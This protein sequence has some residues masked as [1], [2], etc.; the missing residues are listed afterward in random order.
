MKK[1]LLLFFAAILLV[2]TSC[3]K[4]N[5]NDG[6]SLTG[7]EGVWELRNSKSMLIS[8]YPPGNGHLISFQGNNYEMKD[9]GQVTKSGEFRIIE[10][11]T[12]GEATC[13]NIPEGKFTNRIV[14]DNSMNA[15]KIFYELS[16]NKLTIISGC[17]AFDA[18]V[19]LE[20][21]RQ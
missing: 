6:E 15:T 2:I 11:L 7:L 10:D 1:L 14:Y 13:L 17:F 12:A 5:K 20:Y 4:E 3:K 21:E 19:S 8:T 18:G 16:G 9:N